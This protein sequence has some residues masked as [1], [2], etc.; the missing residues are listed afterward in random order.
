[1]SPEEQLSELYRTTFG[2]CPRAVVKL[3]GAGSSRL[4][5]RLFAPAE[6]DGT[7][8]S[9]IGTVGTDV[10]ENRAF[11]A[12][13][14]HFRSKGIAV[15]EV[16]ASGCG[17]RCYLQQ[18][19]GDRQLMG[20]I[21]RG[22]VDGMMDIHG[23]VLMERSVELLAKV[24]Y[25]GAQG[26]DFSVCYP[27]AAM[28]RRMIDWD[29]SYF[30]YCFLK[31][32][33]IDVPENALQD[34]FDRLGNRLEAVAREASTFM[35]R[36]FQSRNVMIDAD[37]Q[38]FLIDFQGG[39]RG[40][41]E[42]D[43]ASFLWQAKAGVS[44]D[45]KRRL[46]DHYVSV[47]KTLDS[48]FDEMRFRRNLPLFVLFRL[49]QVLGAYG[50]RGWQEGKAHFIQSIPAALASVSALLAGDTGDE[51]PALKECIARVAALDKVAQLRAEVVLPPYDGLTVK[52]FSF[53]YKRGVPQDL[54]GNGGGFLFDCRAV[55]N[56]GRY[57]MYKSLTGRDEPVRRFL[58]DDGEI[59]D[60][61]SHCRALVNMSVDR[62]LKRGFS[63]LS[64]GFGCTGGQHRSVY[65]AESMARGIKADYPQVRVL[66]VHVVQNIME[67]L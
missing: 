60:F 35:V 19:L 38:P 64:V 51:Y 1:M 33:G 63:S 25:L 3:P 54:S 31:T 4:Y 5:F 58:E 24:Q 29:L 52:V 40:P 11:L 28:N 30:K 7:I 15:P 23:T 53:S 57:E 18:D 66:L 27:D 65:S 36:D 17:D 9:V 48:G 37:G 43:V 10:A 22:R 44:D 62:Y 50:F 12:L 46:I 34:D 55:H 32:S 45:L 13:G 41:A 39:R 2:T 67:V 20:E 49:L 59:L 47:V 14:R 16:F 26:L 8:P 61:L 21:A 6:G 56:P 42:Y